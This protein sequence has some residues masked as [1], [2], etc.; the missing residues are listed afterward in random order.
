MN[1]NLAYEKLNEYAISVTNYRD[2]R[3]NL[4]KSLNDQLTSLLSATNEYNSNMSAF[5]GNVNTFSSSASALNNIVTNQLN[6]LTISSNCT[7][8]A[9]TLRFF[10]NM[11]CV[12]FINRS[13]KI[14]NSLPI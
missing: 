3:I 7:I 14:G 5:T 6:G 10:Y 11:Y 2:S 4:Y 9:D 8:I 13:V 12:N 1:S